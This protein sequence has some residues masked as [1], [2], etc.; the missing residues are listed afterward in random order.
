MFARLG[1]RFELAYLLVTGNVT[2]V[3]KGNC[4]LENARCLDVWVTLTYPQCVFQ[5]RSDARSVATSHVTVLDNTA[6]N[7]PSNPSVS[8]AFQL[9]LVLQQ[10][11]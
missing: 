2:V 4:E 6:T 3:G 1:L 10:T 9:A 5:G 11:L 7:S 8:M